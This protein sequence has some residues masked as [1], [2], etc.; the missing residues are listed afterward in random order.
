MAEELQPSASD[1]VSSWSASSAISYLTVCL[2]DDCSGHVERIDLL[3]YNLG[4]RP[5]CAVKQNMVGVSA[6]I[7]KKAEGGRSRAEG[8]RF[9][10]PK[11]P[12]GVGFPEIFWIFCL[13]MVHFACILA[14]D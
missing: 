5:Y 10:A 14:H 1:D 12:R 9:E 3:A 7:R 6:R 13:A 4:Q 11:A 2:Y 8:A